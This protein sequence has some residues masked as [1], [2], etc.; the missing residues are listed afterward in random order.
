MQEDLY[1]KLFK[2]FQVLIRLHTSP[3]YNKT[4]TMEQGRKIM[5]AINILLDVMQEVRYKNN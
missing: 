4:F 5:Q 1:P 3:L 2:V